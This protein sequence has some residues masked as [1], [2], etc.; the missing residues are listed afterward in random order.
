MES[1]PGYSINPDYAMADN[2]IPD[3]FLAAIDAAASLTP[4]NLSAPDWTLI[5]EGKPGETYWSWRKGGE[6]D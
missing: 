6:S 2:D 5:H 4:E 3:K 1:N